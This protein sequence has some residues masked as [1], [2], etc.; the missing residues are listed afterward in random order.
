MQGDRC[1]MMHDVT[2]TQKRKRTNNSNIGDFSGSLH[3]GV[4]VN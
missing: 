1:M 3:S 2:M 4:I